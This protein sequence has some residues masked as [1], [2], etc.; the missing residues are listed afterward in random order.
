MRVRK[1]G[2]MPFPKDIFAKLNATDDTLVPISTQRSHHKSVKPSTFP[3][4]VNE[5]KYQ[6]SILTLKEVFLYELPS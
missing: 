1:D 3:T 4:N 6:K 5:G 2:F